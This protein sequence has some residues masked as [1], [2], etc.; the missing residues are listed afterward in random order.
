MFVLEILSVGDKVVTNKNV[1]F[2]SLN[3]K[4]MLRVSIV[5]PIYNVEQWVRRCLLSVCHQTYEN[6]ECIIVNDATP[7]NSMEVVTSVLKEYRGKIEFKTVTHKKNLGL[8]AA[9]NTGVKAAS[10]DYLFFLDSDDELYSVDSISLFKKYIDCYGNADFILGDC[11]VMG[12]GVLVNESMVYCDKPDLILRS[13]FERKWSIVACSKFI[14]RSFFIAKGL[15]FKEGL[16]HEDVAFSF[17]LAF[18][19]NSMITMNEYVYTYNVHNNSIT[20]NKSY[21][22][23]IDYLSIMLGNYNLI[24]FKDLNA[25]LVS[26]FF[27]QG[28]F[29][30]LCSAINNPNMTHSDKQE[31]LAKYKDA[32]KSMNLCSPSNRKIYVEY[33]L[34]KA[35]SKVLYLIIAGLGIGRRQ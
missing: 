34:L 23:Y 15:W 32:V 19:A 26:N 13:Y 24:R 25:D 10:G 29:G 7:D 2:Y 21:K 4:Y 16:L 20:T 35:N 17:Y 12:G 31:I 33:M 30:F 1:I 11:F 9:R 8:S 22:N 5:I 14:K 3:E 28:L 27:I 6:I 18:Y